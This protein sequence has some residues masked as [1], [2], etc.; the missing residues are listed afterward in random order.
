MPRQPVVAAIALYI[1]LG[2]SGEWE[3]DCIREGT[4]KLGYRELPHELCREPSWP[5][6][7][8]QALAKCRRWL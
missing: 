7:E 5:E 6:V 3:N 2:R 1:K 4:L 8:K